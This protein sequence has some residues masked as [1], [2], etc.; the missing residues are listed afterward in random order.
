ML[1]NSPPIFIV[2]PLDHVVNLK[3]H[4]PKLIGECASIYLLFYL[5]IPLFKK[6]SEVKEDC[7]LSRRNLQKDARI[8]KFR[9][10]KWRE[11]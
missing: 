9:V 8:C 6:K 7:R 2:C 4:S 11:L 10:P 1:T 3:R 5:W